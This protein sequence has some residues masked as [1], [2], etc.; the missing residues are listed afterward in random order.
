MTRPQVDPDSSYQ[1]CRE[2]SAGSNPWLCQ[3]RDIPG[4]DCALGAGKTRVL[5]RDSSLTLLKL[6]QVLVIP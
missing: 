4:W 3:Q 1:V 5:S 2:W 6:K